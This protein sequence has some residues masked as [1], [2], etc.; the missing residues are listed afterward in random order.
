MFTAHVVTARTAQLTCS[1]RRP[2]SLRSK[3]QWPRAAVGRLYCSS[4]IVSDGAVESG[5]LSGNVIANFSLHVSRILYM[6]V[7]SWKL[8]SP[9]HLY[10][11][12]EAGNHKASGQMSVRKLIVWPFSCSSKN[13]VM[14]RKELAQNPF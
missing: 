2:L 13:K 7:K 3:L 1:S 8:I 10:G 5:R 6:I 9:G 4:G 12:Q 14:R 11:L